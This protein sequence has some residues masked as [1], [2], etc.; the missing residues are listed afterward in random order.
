MAG[1]EA[2][3]AVALMTGRIFELRMGHLRSARPPLAGAE[4]ITYS[5]T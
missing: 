4:I 3:T 1:G 2:T 5:L